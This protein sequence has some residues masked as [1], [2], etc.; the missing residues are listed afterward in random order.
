M[1]I[2]NSLT[3]SNAKG[4]FGQFMAAEVIKKNIQEV[5]GGGANDFITNIVSAVANNPALEECDYKSIVSSALLGQSLKLSPAPALGQFYV[6]PYTVKDGNGWIKKAQFQIGYK[7]YIQLAIRSGQYQDIDVLDIREGEY[8]GRSQNTG[9]PIFSFV[10]NEVERMKLKVIGYM[11]TFTYLSGFSKAIYCSVEELQEH[12]KKYSKSYAAGKTSL[13]NTDFDSMAR[14]TVL[15][16]LLSKWGML[17][18]DMQ[19]A[20]VKDH[21]VIEADGTAT[22]VDNMVEIEPQPQPQSK[23][24]IE[25]TSEEFIEPEKNLIKKQMEFDADVF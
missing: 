6:V 4:T 1:A 13:W 14:K 8:S 9:K 11:A 24:Q 17:S 2:T 12:A 25:N 19:T 23:K 22:Y 10:Q 3:K 18:V 5:C 7:G 20:V 15:R 16:K 21:A